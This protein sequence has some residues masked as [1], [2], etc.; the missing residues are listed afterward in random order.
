MAGK[1]G[2]PLDETEVSAAVYG[3]LLRVRVSA[4]AHRIVVVDPTGGGWIHDDEAERPTLAALVTV[5]DLPT[6]RNA[7][8]V[9]FLGPARPIPPPLR[10]RQSD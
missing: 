10:L 6:V 2:R 7:N 4:P 1:A 8:A 3:A 5:W 9:Q